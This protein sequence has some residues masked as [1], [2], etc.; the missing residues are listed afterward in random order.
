M[1]RSRF[2]I[3]PASWCAPHR[4][5]QPDRGRHAVD[6]E[7][8]PAQLERRQEP[9]DQGHLAGRELVAGDGR[10]Q[11][12]EG[13]HHRQVGGRHPGQGDRTLYLVSEAETALG[14]VHLGIGRGYKETPERTIVKLVWSNSF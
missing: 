4:R 14:S 10:D 5:E 7:D 11:Q 6:L 13:E 12:A 1:V 9:D 3:T 2:W 8:E